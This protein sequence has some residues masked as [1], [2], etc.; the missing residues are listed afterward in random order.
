MKFLDTEGVRQLK[1]LND[2]AYVGKEEYNDDTMVISAALNDL[3]SR[4]EDKQDALTFDSTPTS[5]STNP[6]TSGGVYTALSTAGDS[7]VIETVKVNG[8]AL[9]VTD[10]A[11]DV[12]VPTTLASLTDDSTHRLVTDTEKTTWNSKIDSADAQRYYTVSTSEITSPK[13][14]DIT[15]TSE[16]IIATFNSSNDSTWINYGS[17]EKLDVHMD[18]LAITD[19][20]SIKVYYWTSWS[21][22]PDPPTE[23]ALLY[24]LYRTYAEDTAGNRYIYT[25]DSN[26][27]WWNGV[28]LDLPTGISGPTFNYL[29][30][31]EVSNGSADSFYSR[32]SIRVIIPKKVQEYYNGSWILRESTPFT[33]SEKT[34]LQGIAA[35]AEVNVQSDWSVTDSTSDAYIANKPT[36]PTK[37]SDL[38][39]DSGFTTNTGTITGITMNGAS[40]GTSGVVDLGTV[41]TDVSGKADASAAIGT[42]SL[43]IDNTNYQITL[44][45]TKV[46][47]TTFTVSNVIDLPLESVV[48]NGSYNNTT[49]KVVLTLQNGNTVDFSVADLVA[50]LQSE[51]TL[52]N[53]L[54]ADLISDGTTNKV[55]TATEKSTWNGKEDA[56]NK[57]TSLSSSSTD[58]QYPSAKAV[59]DIVD[60]TQK[61]FSTTPANP[62]E[63]DI[64][65]VPASSSSVILDTEVSVTPPTQLQFTFNLTSAQLQSIYDEAFQGR[66]DNVCPIYLNGDGLN[67]GGYLGD[68]NPHKDGDTYSLSYDYEG[69]NGTLSEIVPTDGTPFILDIPE[70]IPYDIDNTPV[71]SVC[72]SPYSTTMSANMQV[73]VGT[74]G[75][76]KEYLNGAWVDR[77]AVGVTGVK[78]NSEESYRTGNVNITAANIGAAASSH[79]H[80]WLNNDGSI[81]AGNSIANGDKL[82]FCDYSNSN[83]IIKS[84]V[85]FDGSTT[86]KALT[87]KGT[88]ETFLQTA[89]VTSVNGNTGAVTI[90]VPTKVSDLTNDSGYI[91]G[92]TETDPVFSASAAA[93]I[94]SSDIT[95][96]NGKTSNTGTITSV[97]MNGST[98]SSSGEADLGTVITSHA[99][100]K[101]TATNGTATSTSG[102]ITYVESLTGTNTATDGDLTVTATRKTVTIP[103][104][105][106][107]LKTNN[108]TAQTISASE[109]LTGTINLHKVAKTGTYSDLIGT[110]TIP[111]VNDSTISI[112]KG[113]TAVDS[114]T[115]N[116]AS[117]KTINIPNELPSYSSSDSGKILSVNSSGALVWIIPS[118][119]YSGSSAP[120]SSTG[121]NGDVYLQTS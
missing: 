18:P 105:P 70:T 19:L 109:S 15:S 5:G 4:L 32:G 25:V 9:T 73:T 10:K 99:K 65:V 11:V 1:E 52:T 75:Q 107:T 102:T 111:T 81:S 87:Q 37:V 61:V 14:G 36:I 60:S 74:T 83:K 30:L 77:G 79:T 112:Q 38:T 35:G 55:V 42:L 8:T 44:S 47:G 88:F 68:I 20:T 16:Q 59:Y 46:D 56:S 100:H 82:V 39:N 24:T 101:L 13:E 7:N 50:G 31:K 93:G 17:A 58:T 116:A 21:D 80:G 12:T 34:K 71:T 33:S 89:P 69:D 66:W 118:Y 54:S 67:S 62:Q 57:V 64:L 51:I 113:G 27:N 91:T 72:V 98:V 63:G 95:N 49:K 40:K 26:F 114:F 96:W 97:K 121:N 119:I 48:V 84:T 117:A 120:S 53:K 92:Y 41:I 106:G 90:N 103:S 45:G 23:D 85:S 76:N 94:S 108:S 78:G 86:T 6:V 2:A 28:K 43:A 115:T 110:P 22:K 104:A 29:Y 3:N